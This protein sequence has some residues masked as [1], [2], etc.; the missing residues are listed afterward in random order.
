MLQTID[1]LYV[2][3]ITLS[4]FLSYFC[5]LSAETCRKIQQKTD[6]KQ[7]AKALITAPLITGLTQTLFD[8]KFS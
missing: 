3:N 2:R 8:A 5:N 6:V 7:R 4:Q 1:E